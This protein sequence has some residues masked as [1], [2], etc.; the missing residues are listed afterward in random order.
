MCEVIYGGYFVTEAIYC[1]SIHVLAFQQNSFV[2]VY[3]TSYHVRIR[4]ELKKKSII[5]FWK[6]SEVLL[7]DF[8]FLST[9]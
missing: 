4:A 5:H 6:V 2:F 7:S 1:D 3:L 8:D 9:H